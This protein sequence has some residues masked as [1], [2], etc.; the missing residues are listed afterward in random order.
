MSI[1]KK[2]DEI[3]KH[4]IMKEKNTKI[5]T[6]VAI[7]RKLLKMGNHIVDIKPR[8]DNPVATVFVF[9]YNDKLEIDI[10]EII[11]SNKK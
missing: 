9:L 8:H 6:D 1:S 4:N 2:K 5:I 7:A 11:S 3:E 10:K